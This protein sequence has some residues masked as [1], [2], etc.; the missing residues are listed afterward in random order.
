MKFHYISLYHNFLLLLSVSLIFSV[1]FLTG[2]TDTNKNEGFTVKSWFTRGYGTSQ[3]NLTLEVDTQW[4]A[5]RA[6]LYD[7]SAK[8]VDY[9]YFSNTTHYMSF[10]ITQN[11][12]STPKFGAYHLS[13]TEIIAGKNHSVVKKE[14]ILHEA[15][16]SI[17]RCIPHWEFDATLQSYIFKSVNLTIENHGDFFGF[18]YEGRIIVDNR[19]IFLAPDY[20]WHDL[21][22]WIE[23]GGNVSLDLPV[24]VPVQSEGN[25][26]V[27]IFL[28]DKQLVTVAFYESALHPPSVP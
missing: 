23:P 27:K 14:V 28:Q 7:P 12:Y 2:C 16:F 21:N 8:F 20:H 24:A 6:D 5:G 11:K 9:M 26:D 1:V 3:I 25:H 13:A 4:S 22:L 17:T 15:N 18:I 10:L 19:S